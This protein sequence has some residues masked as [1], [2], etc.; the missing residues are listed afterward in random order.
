MTLNDLRKRLIRETQGQVRQH[1]SEKDA[2]LSKTVLVLEDLDEIFNLQCEHARDLYSLHFPELARLVPEN[3]LYVKIVL[4]LG[5]RENFSVEKILP[6]YSNSSA[7]QHISSLS[8][9]SMGSE[10][11]DS[12]LREIEFLCQNAVYVLQEREELQEFVEKEARQYMPNLSEIASPLLAAKL[13]GK[14]G[15][16]KRLAFMPS[17]AL[18]LLGAEKALFR[19]LKEHSLPPKHG[20][21]FQHSFVQQVPA[22]ARGEMARSLSGKLSIAAK[23]DYFSKTLNAAGLKKELEARFAQLKEKKFKPKKQKPILRKELPQNARRKFF[24]KFRKRR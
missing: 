16:L 8:K 18:Q 19:H 12:A 10:L 11:D 23:Q 1:F 2:L 21:I 17:S 6:F 22:P 5:K 3:G 4:G 20:L 7:C 14:C 13:L 15:S 24:S 9:Q